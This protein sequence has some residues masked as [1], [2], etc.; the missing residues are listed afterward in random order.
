M[1]EYT[2]RICWK[3]IK[4]TNDSSLQVHADSNWKPYKYELEEAREVANS[5]LN[6]RTLE[7]TTQAY[8]NASDEEKRCLNFNYAAYAKIYKGRT[9]VEVIGK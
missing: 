5:I 8:E 2:V 4:R 1:K 6:E 9:C 3:S 7:N